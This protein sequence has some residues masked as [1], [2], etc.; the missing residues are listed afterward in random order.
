MNDV[1]RAEKLVD[2]Y[3]KVSQ[4]D[5]FAEHINADPA[6]PYTPEEIDL[7]WEVIDRAFDEGFRL[8]VKNVTD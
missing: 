2:I 8:G 5:A 3:T 7:L 1:E 6:T 4:R